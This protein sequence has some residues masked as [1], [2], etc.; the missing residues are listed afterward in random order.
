MRC[1][2]LP[3]KKISKC[4]KKFKVSTVDDLHI[5]KQII[6]K[7]KWVNEHSFILICWPPEPQQNIK[8]VFGKFAKQKEGFSKHKEGFSKQKEG[9]SKQKEGFSNH[10]EGFSKHDFKT[11]ANF[12]PHSTV[13]QIFKVIHFFL[14]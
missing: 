3:F 8:F 6:L 5:C 1:I 10:K 7:N 13:L 2:L 12:R 14:S 4:L 9:F 11:F